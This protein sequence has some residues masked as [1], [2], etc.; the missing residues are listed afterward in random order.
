VLLKIL[1]GSKSTV[2]IKLRPQ[3]C[4][5]REFLVVLID[6]LFGENVSEKIC[7]VRLQEQFLK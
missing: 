5:N 3:A 4:I 6:L 1:S 2:A 7:L